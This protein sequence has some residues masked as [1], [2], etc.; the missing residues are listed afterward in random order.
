[1]NMTAAAPSKLRRRKLQNRPRYD[2]T[3][4]LS[5]LTSQP[6]TWLSVPLSDLPDRDRKKNQVAVGNIARRHIGVIQT[7]TETDTLFVRLAI[8]ITK[9]S[10]SKKGT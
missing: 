8:P 1:M 5:A 9:L 3:S 4:V 2:W 7:Q 6:G 10:K